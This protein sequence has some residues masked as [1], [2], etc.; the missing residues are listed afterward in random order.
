MRAAADRLAALL[1]V[2]ALA[3]LHLRDCSM[4]TT[5]YRDVFAVF[6]DIGT[7]R[8]RDQRCRFSRAAEARRTHTVHTV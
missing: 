6:A 2:T 3:R 8:T 1:I 5:R 7:R 4:V